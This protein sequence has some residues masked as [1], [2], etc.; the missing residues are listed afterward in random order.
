MGRLRRGIG[1]GGNAVFSGHV[2]YADAVSWAG[3]DFRGRGV[4]FSLALLSPGDVIEVE[5]G[6]ER[7]RY[8]VQ[9]QK[10]VDASDT[11]AWAEI[12]SAQV[13]QDSIT[14]ITC[15]GQFNTAT[16]SYLDRTVVRAVRS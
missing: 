9:W 10:Q 13:E 11:G 15:G 7:L 5:V 14:I 16:R 1:G 6:G 4:F 12:L 2:D 8:T 3:V